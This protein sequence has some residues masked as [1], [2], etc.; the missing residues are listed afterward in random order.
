MTLKLTAGL[1][2]LFIT[3]VLQFLLAS[4]GIH[5]NLSFVALICF[6]F[7][8]EFWELAALILLAVFIIN[9]QP[10]VSIEILI[11]A[12]Y[13]V[14]VHFSRNIVHWQP[15]IENFF[16]IF[17]GFVIL[18]GAVLGRAFLYHPQSFLMEV[19]TGFIFGAVVFLPLYHWERH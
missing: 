19:T 3:L 8:F 16:A 7:V 6:A 2:I 1:V 13:P 5:L 4:A 9:W 10:G 18:Y 17:L 12:L 11:F 15:W 14:V